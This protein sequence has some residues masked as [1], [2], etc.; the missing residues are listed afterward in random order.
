M[1]ATGAAGVVGA[2]AAV[3]GRVVPDPVV[4]APVAVVGARVAVVGRVVPGPVVVAPVV[5]AVVVG[6][7]AVVVGRVVPDPVV[8][9]LVADRTEVA[10]ADAVPQACK[11]S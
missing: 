10:C 5:P 9:A 6:A 4:V 7:R 11:A 2:R 8:V 3:V 1:A